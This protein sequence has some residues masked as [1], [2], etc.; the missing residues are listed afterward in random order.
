[1]DYLNTQI[2]PEQFLSERAMTKPYTT[3]KLSVT[4]T[5]KYPFFVSKQPDLFDMY[6][7]V[8]KHP[9]IVWKMLFG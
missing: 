2:V 4:L 7:S 1:M 5:P 6:G 3:A 8:Y 9:W